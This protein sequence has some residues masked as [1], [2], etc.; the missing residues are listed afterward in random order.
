[1][2]SGTKIVLLLALLGVSSAAALALVR[3]HEDRHYYESRG[4]R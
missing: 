2:S 4:E 1:M 3:W